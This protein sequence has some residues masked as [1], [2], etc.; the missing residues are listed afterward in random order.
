MEQVVEVGTEGQPN[1]CYSSFCRWSHYRENQNN[2]AFITKRSLALL[3]A[4][5]AYGIAIDQGLMGSETILPNSSKLCQ[6][7]MIM[8]HR[9]LNGDLG[10]ALN[11]FHGI[12]WL[13]DLSHPWKGYVKGYMEKIIWDSWVRHWESQW[14]GI[15]TYQHTNGYQTNNGLYHKKHVISK[16]EAADGRGVW[17]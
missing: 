11:P 2:H 1:R 4:L 16:I 5:L 13:T 10:E 8:A 12:S 6:W 17:E 15:I 3:Q 7:N 14:A 9:R